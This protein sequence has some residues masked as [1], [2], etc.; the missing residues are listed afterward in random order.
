MSGKLYK[1]KTLK[2]NREP[3]RIL[4]V[5]V[6]VFISGISSRYTYYWNVN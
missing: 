2:L 5:G 6:G 1:K 4:G 3:K